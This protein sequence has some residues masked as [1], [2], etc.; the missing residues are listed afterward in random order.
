MDSNLLCL[1]W[2]NGRFRAA[3][4]NR[5]TRGT[6][7]ERPG[8]VEDF[9]GFEDALSEAVAATHASGRQV[10]IVLAHPRHIHQLLEMPPLKGANLG[11]FLRRRVP[12]LK[13]FDGDAAWACQPAMPTKNSHAV[14]LHIF[15]QNLVDQLVAGCAKLDLELVRLLPT[16]AVLSSQLK[17]LPVPREELAMVVAETGSS[18]TVVIGTSDG[19]V[20][21]GRVLQGCWE[22]QQDSL[23]VD[24]TRTIGFAEQQSGLV[25]GSVWLFGAEV[26][27]QLAGLEAALRLPVQ[28]SPVEYT[29]YY[30]A[31][32]AAKLP[33]KDDGNLLSV[34]LR[35]APRR[36]RLLTATGL[37]LLILLV[38]A[39]GVTGFVEVLRKQW[40]GMLNREKSEVV[41][42]QG[43]LADWRQRHAELSR[44]RDYIR[45]VLVE[46]P[47]PAGAWFLGYLNEAVPDEL[48][49]KEL[50]VLR[51][52]EG[53]F[54]SLG[55]VAQPTTN[56]APKVAITRA[57]TAMTNALVTG[58]FR[59]RIARNLTIG[60][61]EKVGAKNTTNETFLLE[62]M[63][64]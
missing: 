7:W 39:L 12:T 27:G 54:V 23:A 64:Q 51:T 13:T 63:I 56:T 43:V 29:P 30:W 45:I 18:T 46:K 60:R 25:V 59:L 62:G 50:R 38:V 41:R 4:L 61:R 16:T 42:L 52:N 11:K 14:L 22:Q 28:P 58:P 55:G 35:E 53:W 9:A 48:L 10:A 2:L 57:S 31:E 49:L 1:S 40:V 21:L 37:I 5:G 17:G 15:P 20:C 32:Q 34:Q 3:V 24:L 19:R 47:I 26:P 33:E 8:V 36:R 44:K 6:T